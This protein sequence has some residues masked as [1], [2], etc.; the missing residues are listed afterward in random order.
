MYLLDTNA[1]V[2]LERGNREAVTERFLTVLP[3]AVRVSTV[4]L[5]EL[6]LGAA[7][8]RDPELARHAVD[9]L[10][11]GFSR[12]GVGARVASYYAEITADL[13][14]R[15]KLIGVNDRWIAAQAL[16]ENLVLVSANT[17]EF[18]RVRD[19]RLENW[20]VR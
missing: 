5:G 10:V 16:A 12:C 20:R 19:L 4:V 14:Q 9:N 11:G 17:S 2:D 8:S 6:L 1:W 13:A 3:S 7:R 18:S 15:G